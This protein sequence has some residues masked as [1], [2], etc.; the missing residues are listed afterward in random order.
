M[1]YLAMYIDD[2]YCN[3]NEAGIN[4]S[5]EGIVKNGLNVTIKDDLEDY[6]SCEI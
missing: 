1:V 5:I 2:C 3:G 6:L 4:D